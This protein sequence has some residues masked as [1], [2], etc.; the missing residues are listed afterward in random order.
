MGSN[1]EVLRENA[2]II[3]AYSA[4]IQRMTPRIAI[5]NN[6]EARENANIVESNGET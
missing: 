3:K 4:R 2:N 1:E 6:E 5:G